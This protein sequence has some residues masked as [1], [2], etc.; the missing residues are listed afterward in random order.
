MKY[1]A[2][3]DRSSEKGNILFMILMAVVLLGVLTAAVQ[4]TN[5]PEGANID[6]ETIVIRTTE[7]QRYAAELERAVRYIIQ[8]GI[9][10]SDIRFAH[11]DA[12]SDYGDL[13][14]DI[15]K[16]DQVFHRDGGGAAYRAPPNGVNDGSAW[17]FYGGT[18]LP[19]MGSDRA[20]LVAVLPNVSEAFCNR[21]NTL[22]NQTTQPEDTGSGA[23][24]GANPGE[25]IH[26]GSNGRFGNGNTFYA[27]PNTT[28]IT[29]FVTKPAGQACVQCVGATG[30]PYHFY[31]VLMAR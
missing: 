2:D 8:N 9:S 26:L 29:T 7:V 16:R 28:D 14:A 21:I 10:E 17:E 6:N 18:D 5:R 24:S 27:A 15:D 3:Q 12:S 4:F 20:D 22:A 1:T 13:S 23:A 11:P 19:E 25:C 31:H 30:A